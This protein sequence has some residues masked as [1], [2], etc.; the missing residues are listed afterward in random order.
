MLLEFYAETLSFNQRLYSNLSS[1]DYKNILESL[2]DSGHEDSLNSFI[3]FMHV[4]G[5]LRI[6][7]NRH[8]ES[9]SSLTS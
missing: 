5:L 4:N 1:N 9:Q 3:E 2:K 8:V 7:T 6:S